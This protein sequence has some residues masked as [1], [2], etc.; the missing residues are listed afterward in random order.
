MANAWSE[1]DESDVQLFEK[2]PC[3]KKKGQLSRNIPH[4]HPKPKIHLGN[5]FFSTIPPQLPAEDQIR[6]PKKISH[7]HSVYLDPSP[8]AVLDSLETCLEKTEEDARRFGQT[9]LID[10]SMATPTPIV[11]GAH[12]TLQTPIPITHKSFLIACNS[13]LG[14]QE[15][16]HTLKKEVVDYL[17]SVYHLFV[18]TINGTGAPPILFTP[19]S[20]S[21]FRGREQDIDGKLK[22]YTL[23]KH[24]PRQDALNSEL[25]KCHQYAALFQ[26]KNEGSLFQKELAKFLC[27]QKV[28]FS[29]FYAIETS[30]QKIGIPQAAA[31]LRMLTSKPSSPVTLITRT[32]SALER[33]ED[34][35][36]DH[37]SFLEVPSYAVTHVHYM[38]VDVYVI[39]VSC[40]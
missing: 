7:F 20:Y 32:R 8:S 13:G 26:Q 15:P 4:R 17:N 38:P 6:L 19:S 40:K 23:R 33:L 16:Y 9:L 12:S 30:H 24:T 22:K 35:T 2:I 14:R 29:I 36:F 21:F 37:P 27:L 31:T 25:A 1:N 10:G 3:R 34:I 11:F 5:Y 18:D 39:T 28:L